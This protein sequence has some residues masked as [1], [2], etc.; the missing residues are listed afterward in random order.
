MYT[1]SDA[2]GT[3]MCFLHLAQQSTPTQEVSRKFKNLKF[4]EKLSKS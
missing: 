3:Q 1:Q 2:I 4:S